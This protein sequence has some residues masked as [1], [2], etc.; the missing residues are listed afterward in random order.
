[1]RQAIKLISIADIQSLRAISDNV[2]A[3]RLDPYILEAQEIDLF[4]LIG[5]DLYDKLFTEADPPTFPATYLYSELKAEYGAYLAYM[6]YAR[7]LTQQQVTITSHGVVTKRTDFS[8]SVSDTTMQRVISAARATASVYAERLIDF[9][10]ENVDT[11]PEWKRCEH[12]EIKTG[13]NKGTARITAVKGRDSA[14]RL[15]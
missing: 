14:W 13:N 7:F 3:D 5:K 15:R 6:A 12:C 9:L 8:D 11:Y 4:G 1:M 2:P 10:N